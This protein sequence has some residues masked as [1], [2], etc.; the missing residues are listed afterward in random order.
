MAAEESLF[1]LHRNKLA[2][3]KALL[4]ETKGDF[5]PALVHN[6][7]MVQ[8]AF[9][10]AARPADAAPPAAAAD[11]S[12]SDASVLDASLPSSVLSKARPATRSD[13]VT[14][15]FSPIKPVVPASPYTP[16]LFAPAPQTRQPPRSGASLLSCLAPCSPCS[17][18]T[19]RRRTSSPPSC[20][21]RR[22]RSASAHRP[23]RRSIRSR[24]RCRR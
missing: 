12:M 13:N 10:L 19:P 17:L 11:V 9:L 2:E 20:R 7:E 1:C 8:P 21:P 18:Q 16:S 22:A 3:A 24:R 5:I 14:D 4:P 15:L 23:R 6:F